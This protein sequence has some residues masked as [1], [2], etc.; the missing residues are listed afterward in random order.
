MVSESSFTSRMPAM[1]ATHF[2]VVVSVKVISV[3]TL[4]VCP[5]PQIA[6]HVPCSKLIN[7]LM[8]EHHLSSSFKFS[9]SP[10]D[11]FMSCNEFVKKYS[12]FEAVQQPERHNR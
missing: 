6:S 5:C 1:S 12:N 3:Q 8:G 4:K 2:V 9:C 11:G 7:S 10:H